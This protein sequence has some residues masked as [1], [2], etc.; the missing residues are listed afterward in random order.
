[1]CCRYP[2]DEGREKATP[3]SVRRSTSASA[4]QPLDNSGQKI[5]F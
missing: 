5:A 4:S 2:G 1:M 3:G